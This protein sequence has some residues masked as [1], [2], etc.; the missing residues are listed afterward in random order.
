MKAIPRVRRFLIRIITN[1]QKFDKVTVEQARAVLIDVDRELF[2]GS[3]N[4]ER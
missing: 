4:K 2:A 3:H 1:P